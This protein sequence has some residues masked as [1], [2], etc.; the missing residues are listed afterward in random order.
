MKIY[1][2]IV[3]DM[4]DNFAVLEE[5]SV[6][7]DGDILLAK[8]GSPP[9]ETPAKRPTRPEGVTPEEIELGSEEVENAGTKL[10]GKRSLIKPST[11]S[12][13]DLQV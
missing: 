4:K 12:S 3:L 8:G 7:Y 13:S 10:R 1:K 2:K 6:Q 5:D 9:A 11:G